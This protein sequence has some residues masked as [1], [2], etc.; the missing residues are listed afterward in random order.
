MPLFSND[1]VGLATYHLPPNFS[2]SPLPLG[3]IELGSILNNLQDLE[4]INPE[5]R[6]EIPKASIYCHQKHGFTATRSSMRKGEFGVWARLVG[7][8][9]F[10]GELSA[11]SGFSDETEYNI[12]RLDTFTFTPSADYLAVSMRE[13][14]VAEYVEATDWE[15]VYLVTGIKVAVGP[16]VRLT[17]TTSAV[18]KVEMG[19]H[20]PASLPVKIGPRVGFEREDHV[21]E[22]WETSDD[23]IFGLRVKKL[24][25]KRGWLVRW[26][27]EEGQLRASQF[28]KGAQLVGLDDNDDESEEGE[29]IVE[30]DVLG[31][32]NVKV[33]EDG[34]E[35]TLWIIL[36]SD[37]R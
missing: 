36:E 34:E 17:K 6:I 21:S 26:R 23:F 8:E 32:A 31:G 5:S 1:R 19:L 2:I 30:L 20:E 37:P 12:N 9:G 22:V 7:M 16:S 13:V 3:P 25:Y 11:S 33:E 15:P 27:G 4:V 29:E 24:V 10:R 14:E 35:E 18:V 28:N